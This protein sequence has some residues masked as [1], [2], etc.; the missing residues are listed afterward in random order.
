MDITQENRFLQI[1]TALG[2]KV[3]L[4]TAMHGTEAISAPF[5]FELDLV[6]A[7]DHSIN[8]D[9]V[10]AKN[11]TVS[12]RLHD[13][14][15][16]FFN[17]YF[18]SFAQSRTS[19]EE[20]EGKLLF[21]HYRATMVPWLW[22]LTTTSNIRI[23]QNKT[24]PDIVEKIFGDHGLNDYELD[25]T[26]TYTPRVYCVQ[27]RETDFNFVSRL[28]EGEGI[29]YFFKHENGKHTMVLSDHVNGHPDLAPHKEV[30]FQLDTGAE[31]EEDVITALD[32]AMSIKPSKYIL[33][34]YNF[35]TPTANLLA[36]TESKLKLSPIEG[37]LYDYPGRYGDHSM[38][39]ERTRCR[40]QEL[41]TALTV[42]SGESGVRSLASGCKFTLEDFPRTDLNDKIY[43][44]TSVTHHIT[45]TS[46][47]SQSRKKEEQ[48][49]Y[50]N[51]FTCIPHAN[52][53]R[54][55]RLTPKP[56]VQGAQT[57][58]VVGTAGEEIEVDKYGRVKVQFH[59]DRE[60][61]ADENSSCWIRVSQA[62]AGVNW[63]AMFIPRIG[64]EV[65]VSFLEGDPDQP[66]ITG[67]V[68]HANNMPP[69]ELP[70][71]KT[72]ST[73]K[74]NSSKGGDGFNEIRF[75]DKK[76]EEQLFIHAEKNMDIRVKNDRFE[77][78]GNNRHLHVSN[79]KR[80]KVDN[81]RSEKIGNDHLEEIGKDRH[82]KVAG[83]E[84]IEIGGSHSLTVKG[85]VIEVFKAKHSEETTGDYY[86]K[87]DNIVIQGM[88]NVTVK[89]GQ[90]FI[91]IEASGIK[92]GTTGQIV[93]EAT[94]T[95]SVKGTAGVTIESPLTATLKS[96]STKVSGDA[97]T[98]ITGG[99]VKIN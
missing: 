74:T 53:F 29:F 54:P 85:D 46:Y 26:A 80:E 43:V 78:I 38:G 95:L 87:A 4:I 9:D 6:S 21:S 2:E 1:K 77:T 8:F 62:V 96:T 3:L 19:T 82:L 86:L 88:T 76:G 72:K 59:W 75:E 39:T 61:K 25:L 42:L 90:S 98:T 12:L 66:I 37:G 40:M 45:Q 17:G 28:L 99:I 58:T 50:S 15:E 47:R 65:I 92:I 32:V 70:G 30:S 97:M 13:G 67:R 69:Y 41:E 10:I 27:Y 44:L 81:N 34:D 64:H 23:F 11:V 16:R 63:G 79:D 22:F 49:T 93:L 5:Q 18:S 55:A 57:A 89:V 7:I 71:E 84:A 56:V 94:N 83:K 52:P 35:E 31:R 48:D 68:Y 14:E 24:V 91:A 60:S 36:E 33:N 51:T 20:E 73:I